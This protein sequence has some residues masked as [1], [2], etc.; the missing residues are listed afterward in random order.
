MF[1]G[2]T[3]V[4]PGREKGREAGN[5]RA[6]G[7]EGRKLKCGIPGGKGSQRSILSEFHKKGEVGCASNSLTLGW[8]T[9]RRMVYT[10]MLLLWPANG[11]PFLLSFYY[12]LFLRLSLT[13]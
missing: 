6:R 5:V 1:A 13:M 8:V 9:H 4:G 7:R 2:G 11:F 10:E 3:P 12:V